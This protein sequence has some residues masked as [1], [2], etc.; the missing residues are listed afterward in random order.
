MQNF[1]LRVNDVIDK[2]KKGIGSVANPTVLL[3]P[4]VHRVVSRFQRALGLFDR[5]K[6]AKLDYK[7]VLAL[8][9]LAL[10]QAGLPQSTIK[11]V[12]EEALEHAIF[13]L[14]LGY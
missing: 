12:L 3:P 14:A 9:A 4:D 8:N 2:R 1:W 10:Q 11:S 7:Q 6:M 5:S 13:S